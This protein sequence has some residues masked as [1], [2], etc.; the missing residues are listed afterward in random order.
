[1]PKSLNRVTLLGHVG[2]DPEI[3]STSNGNKVANLSLAT[4]SYAG[5]DKE[6]K[7]QWHRLVV[8]NRKPTESGLAD[9]VEKY[10]RKGDALY[11]SG[12]IEYRT[13]Q[14]KEGQTKYTTEIIVDDVILLGSGKKEEGAAATKATKKEE[15]LDDFP[16]ALAGGS[17]D[18][19]LPFH[20]MAKGA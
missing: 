1:M 4:N 14:D 12:R 10:V 6:E 7:P 16:S 17:E 5:K 2:G 20:P 13:W 15:G 18:D 11:V 9:V 19:D 3:R 8:W